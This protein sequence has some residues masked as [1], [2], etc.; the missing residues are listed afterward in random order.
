MISRQEKHFCNALD[1]QWLKPRNFGFVDP[2]D[3]TPWG[4]MYVFL[5][6]N[7]D[8]QTWKSPGIVVGKVLESP[9][10]Y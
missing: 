6:V 4:A 7:L 8:F 2:L 3:T 9:G 10:I 1:V 5:Y